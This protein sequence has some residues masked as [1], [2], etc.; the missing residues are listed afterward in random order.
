MASAPGKINSASGVAKARAFRHQCAVRAWK[1]FALAALLAGSALVAAAL[2]TRAFPIA[3]VDFTLSA[4]QVSAR[5]SAFLERMGARPGEARSTVTFG[6]S[7]DE[8]NFVELE[9]GTRRLEQLERAGLAVWYWTG[10]WFR[11]GVNEE[12]RVW[13]SPRGELV[14][15][16]RTVDDAEKIPSL[17]ADA[18]RARATDFLRR[19]VGRHPA[20]RLVY[21]GESFERRPNRVD[22]TFTWERPDLRLADA[23]YELTVTIQGD[24]VGGYGEG[25]TVPDWW[26]RKF[27]RLRQVN[28]LCE[29]VA[30]FGVT[31]RNV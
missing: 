18:A 3:A 6:E 9:Y 5:M 31:L 14:G 13:L 2:W 25:L 27:A 12:H 29:R 11:P 24:T 17:S 8:K 15:Y 20:D 30:G 23:P 26:D 19:K 21:G 16:W 28:E 7:S 1:I 4:A 22:Y 10:R